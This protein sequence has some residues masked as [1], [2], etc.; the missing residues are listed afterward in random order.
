[1]SS[2]LVGAIIFQR[3]KKPMP[4][5]SEVVQELKNQRGLAQAELTRL[6]AAIRLT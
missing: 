1:M 6:D 3:N 5:L 2:P 4:D